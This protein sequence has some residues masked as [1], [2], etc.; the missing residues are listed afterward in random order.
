MTKE[1]TDHFNDGL[2]EPCLCDAPQSICL[3]GG[4]DGFRFLVA[5]IWGKLAWHICLFTYGTESIMGNVELCPRANISQHLWCEY[6]VCILYWQMLI[7]RCKSQ[8][9]LLSLWTLIQFR[10]VGVQVYI[11]CVY[12]SIFILMGKL[13]MIHMNVWRALWRNDFSCSFLD[14]SSGILLRLPSCTLSL[15]ES[16]KRT[17]WNVSSE[18]TSWVNSQV[19]CVVCLI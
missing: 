16:W 6:L 13:G 1:A 5:L 19:F 2:S 15:L 10:F 3:Y 17:D 14:K 7:K 9:N 12:K 8:S 18:F 11:K 4:F